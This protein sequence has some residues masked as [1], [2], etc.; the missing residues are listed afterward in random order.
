[1]KIF[2]LVIIS[3]CTSLVSYAQ[4]KTDG[5]LNL[6]N[7]SR[8]AM[9][10]PKEFCYGG[11]PMLQ[12][13]DSE[14]SSSSERK[15]LIYDENLNLKETLKIGGE[16]TFDYQITFQDEVRD[17]E[18]VSLIREEEQCLYQSYEEFVNREKMVD[19]S[20]DESLL[21]ITE[22]SNGDKL[23]VYNY[24]SSSIYNDYLE[25]F[26]YG[27]SYFGT[28]YPRIYFRLKNDVMYRYT[29]YYSVKYGEWRVSGTRVE[30]KHYN[31]KRLYLCNINL[32]Q[33]DGQANYYFEASQTLFN[34]DEAFEY[35]LPKYVLSEGSNEPTYQPTY[36]EQ[37]I[38]TTR[39]TII[40]KKS[41]VVLAGFQVVSSNGTV[42][43]D[44][45][46]EQG[47]I[48]FS[49]PNNLFVVTIGEKT[50]L[51]FSGY[52]NGKSCTIF[53]LIDRQTTEL[54]QV[55]TA[56]GSF[57]ISPTIVDRNTPIN[58][59]FGDNNKSGSDIIVY[60]TSGNQMQR[61]NVPAGEKTA[62]LSI[63]ANSGMFI[64]AR[65]Q[66]GKP[67]ETKKIIVK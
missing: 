45:D 10:I 51:A 14:S 54:R 64:V 7:P 61:Q 27:Y 35:I 24:S 20:F 66:K 29:A 49:S 21:T 11:A 60:S 28:K 32:N 43:R 31:Y 33:G 55:K 48:G 40:T 15:L 8:L 37:S 26:Y 63:S 42:I 46:F 4:I 56:P 17:V 1:M 12:M 23:I 36:D 58:I 30:D 9:S 16:R 50:Y 22:E 5:N 44:L 59:S 19:P 65:Q 52:Q 62:Q 3:L 25:N 6:G 41:N 38:V 67:V 34:N 18:D 13:Y 2:Y 47:F 53:Y 57:V 39:S